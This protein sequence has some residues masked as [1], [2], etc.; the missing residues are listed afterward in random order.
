MVLYFSGTGNSQFVALRLAQLLGEDKAV[1]INQY[2]KSGAKAEFHADRPLVFVAPTYAWRLPKI[3]S[4]WIGAACFDGNRN[5][6]FILTCGGS[7]GNAAAY[8]KKLCEK[9]GLQFSGLALI[10]MPNNYVALSNTPGELECK[11]LLEVAQDNTEALASLIQ[12]GKPFPKTAVSWKDRIN[13]GPVCS[14][15]YTFFVHDKGYTA[16][17]ACISCGKC[18]QRCP[19]NN[20]GIANGKPVWNGCCTHCMACIGGCPV[21]AIEYNSISKGNRRYYIMNDALCWGKE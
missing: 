17:D 2:L 7:V 8:A 19:L 9:A 21:E 12:R 6:Y 16:S 10:A 18:A 11:E 5:A 13:S 15:F 1:S 14:L 3:V 20:I 4:D